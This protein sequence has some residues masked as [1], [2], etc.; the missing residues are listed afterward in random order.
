M[1]ELDVLRQAGR[2]EQM[3]LVIRSAELRE[4]AAEIKSFY[5]RGGN[6]AMRRAADR[7]KRKRGHR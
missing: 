7:A 3:G 2:L 5:E 6:R 4:R 1:N